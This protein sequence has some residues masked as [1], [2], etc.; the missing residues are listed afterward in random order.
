VPAPPQVVVA[1]PPERVPDTRATVAETEPRLMLPS[2][3]R[4]FADVASPEVA[5]ALADLELRLVL[6]K[7]E[8]ALEELI[9]LQRTY[10]NDPRIAGRLARVLQ[11]R[12]L[13]RYGQGSVAGALTDWQRALD[14]D[15]SLR[16]T[17]G[18]L[19]HA[20]RELAAP[21]R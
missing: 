14:L 21:A 4:Q 8:S 1:V 3:A 16:S 2:V 11:Q 13:M 20:A 19:D 10:P 7:L 12:G 15:P 5:A 9:V 17:R 6:G 18:L